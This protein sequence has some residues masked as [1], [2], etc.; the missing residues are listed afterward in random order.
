MSESP[1]DGIEIRDGQTQ[2]FDDF[3]GLDYV[4]SIRFLDSL[5]MGTL[6]LGIEQVAFCCFHPPELDGV[7]VLWRE[8]EREGGREMRQ[9]NDSGRSYHHRTYLT[10]T[11]IHSAL[12]HPLPPSRS[13]TSQDL[14][15]VF[16][17]RLRGCHCCRVPIQHHI[18]CQQGN[19]FDLARTCLYHDGEDGKEEEDEEGEEGVGRRS[20][21]S[22]H[23][24]PSAALLLMKG[25]F[26]V[27][28]QAVWRG[29]LAGEEAPL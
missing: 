14:V 11:K 15:P 24:A 1:C 6:A 26:C 9:S 25:V 10:R 16:P 5:G 23:V 18:V 19:K 4:V 7:D 29:W 27:K 20:C 21:P 22:N 12:P 3:P 17:K 28:R 13:L 2:T 8:E